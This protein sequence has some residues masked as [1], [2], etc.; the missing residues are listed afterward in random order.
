[1]Y[2]GKRIKCPKCKGPINVPAAEATQPDAP[3][4]STPVASSTPAAAPA[5]SE[6][7]KIACGNCQATLKAPPS[8]IGK[9]IACPKCKQPIVVTPNE[10]TPETVVGQ[11]ESPTKLE[12]P[13]AAPPVNGNQT[14]VEPPV[15][16]PPVA[17]PQDA[18]ESFVANDQLNDGDK[19]DGDKANESLSSSDDLVDKKDENDVPQKNLDTRR[20]RSNPAKASR[21]KLMI[22]VSGITLGLGALF[23]AAALYIYLF[24]VPGQTAA[25]LAEPESQSVTKGW[26]PSIEFAATTFEG[27]ASEP[28]IDSPSKTMVEPL[29][30]GAPIVIAEIKAREA[31]APTLEFSTGGDELSSPGFSSLGFELTA[32]SEYAQS[33][34]LKTLPEPL[35]YRGKVFVNSQP[36]TRISIDDGAEQ[37][38]FFPSE[39]FA[40]CLR[41]PEGIFLV[42]LKA[43]EYGDF[44][45]VFDGNEK[46][47]AKHAPLLRKGPFRFVVSLKRPDFPRVM[48]SNSSDLNGD[49]KGVNLIWVDRNSKIHVLENLDATGYDAQTTNVTFKVPDQS[50]GGAIVNASGQIAGLVSDVQNGIGTVVQIPKIIDKLHQQ[51]DEIFDYVR[52]PNSEDQAGKIREASACIAQ[53]VCKRAQLSTHVAFQSNIETQRGQDRSSRQ[54]FIDRYDANFRDS[55]KI[56]HFAMYEGKGCRLPGFLGPPGAAA[57]VEFSEKPGEK[58]RW[59]IVKN[60][61]LGPSGNDR[62]LVKGS[63]NTNVLTHVAQT[64]NY[65]VVKETENHL[66]IERD[67]LAKSVLT[68]PKEGSL[69]WDI[70]AGF[71]FHVKGKFTYRYDKSLKLATAIKFQGVEQ[72]QL[73]EGLVVPLNLSFQMTSIPAE[74]IDQSQLP[75]NSQ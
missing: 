45:T 1:M 41:L 14:R 17:P 73:T 48:A 5:P 8:L 68:E 29:P 71:P 2:Y 21:N 18:D 11:T 27:S 63:R 15:A 25:A 51:G 12:S 37:K 35:R 50:L 28:L 34:A 31:L 6:K 32:K 46:Q 62:I 4:P 54:L 38:S 20:R 58:T 40:T 43:I 24:G 52:T 9:K 26:D 66:I 56:D 64:D 69:Q 13:A 10:L 33:D 49:T 23:V 74:E 61:S 16:E 39:T 60:L 67:Y 65:R 70:P 7:F 75:W 30:Q 55:G 53:L 57:I 19:N 47:D 59:K 72:K 36:S 42:P 44:L 3:V 22:A